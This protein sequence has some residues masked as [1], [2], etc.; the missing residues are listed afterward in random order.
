MPN[1]FNS[2][3]KL[4]AIEVLK[5]AKS[6]GFTHI[7]AFYAYLEEKELERKKKRV[8]SKV[9][10]REAACRELNAELGE[11]LALK[12]KDLFAGRCSKDQVADIKLSTTD[13]VRNEWGELVPRIPVN[14][15]NAYSRIVDKCLIYDSGKKKLHVGDWQVPFKTSLRKSLGD[16]FTMDTHLSEKSTKRVISP[17]TNANN[18]VTAREW[19]L[20][21]KIKR[22]HANGPQRTSGLIAR[23]N[24]DPGTD[25]SLL[26]E[27]VEA[28]IPEKYQAANDYRKYLGR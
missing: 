23:A 11:K 25:R 12:R 19:K 7:G 15:G 14:L 1:T 8:P 13:S 6:F 22:H 9:A 16:T 18:T 24:I 3:N 27:T 17:L 26:L 2:D 28:A 10:K 21:G 4:S 20:R 5:L